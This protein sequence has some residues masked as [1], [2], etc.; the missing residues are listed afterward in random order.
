M[1]WLIFVLL[2]SGTALIIY[3]CVQFFR[4]SYL[5]KKLNHQDLEQYKKILG[6]DYRSRP[7]DT[8]TRRYKWDKGIFV[9]KAHFN[10]N[11][12]MIGEQHITPVFSKRKKK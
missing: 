8:K 12:E 2:L 10:E 5:Q 4:F 6:N 7:I 9:I 3:T 1:E 11:G